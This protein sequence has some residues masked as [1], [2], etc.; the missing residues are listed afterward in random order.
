VADL[1]N[2]V[3]RSAGCELEV[4]DEDIEDPDNCAN[5]LGDLQE[6]FQAVCWPCPT[7]RFLLTVL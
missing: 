3:L 1:V 7:T 5:R 6:E 2:F 4:S